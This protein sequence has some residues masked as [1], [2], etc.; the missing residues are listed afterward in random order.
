LE[1]VV[2]TL[3][4]VYTMVSFQRKRLLLKHFINSLLHVEKFI[5]NCMSVSHEHG[6]PELKEYHAYV[7]L[8]PIMCSQRVV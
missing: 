1:K 7:I 2:I 8:G 4:I 3:L 6:I 5:V